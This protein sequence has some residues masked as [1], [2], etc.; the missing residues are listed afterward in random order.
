MIDV[1]MG[2]T[3]R[4]LVPTPLVEREKG[5]VFHE[6]EFMGSNVHSHDVQSGI[7]LTSS[8]GG[9]DQRRGIKER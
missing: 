8:F 9:F 5:K 4:S 3:L 6:E 7:V 1:Q 2:G